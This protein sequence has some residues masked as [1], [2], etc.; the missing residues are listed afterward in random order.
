MAYT[1]SRLHTG[2]PRN[3]RSIS[4]TDKKLS[5]LH[6][7][8]PA[9]AQSAG[10]GTLFFWVEADGARNLSVIL[11]RPLSQCRHGQSYLTL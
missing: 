3:L 5:L 2:L 9:T 6:M 10:F 4:V 11:I 1:A 7:C 8:T